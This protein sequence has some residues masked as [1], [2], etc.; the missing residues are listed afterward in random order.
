MQAMTTITI[1]E[2]LYQR[3][4]ALA[5]AEQLELADLLE[6]MITAR[7]QQSHWSSILIALQTLIRAS[8]GLPISND[9]ETLVEDL[10][11]A[12]AAIFAAEYAHLY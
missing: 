3:M 4:H 6:Q 8:G 10:R 1:P 2:E 12:R 11:Q 7:E 9:D 5:A